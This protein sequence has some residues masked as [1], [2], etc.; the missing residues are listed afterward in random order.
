MV[1][2]GV[3]VAATVGGTV[4]VGGG[5]AAGAVTRP[6]RIAMTI[7]NRSMTAA[8]PH[9][10]G[11]RAFTATPFP[12]TRQV[13]LRVRPI[14]LPVVTIPRVVRCRCRP[15]ILP[16]PYCIGRTKES[17]MPSA[18]S[19]GQ[20]GCISGSYFCESQPARRTTNGAFPVSSAP[21][22]WSFCCWILQQHG[23]EYKQRLTFMTM[24]LDV[25]PLIARESVMP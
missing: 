25:Y 6:I 23:S 3:T 22:S 12:V 13:L 24:Y 20:A 17:P 21:V 2:V 11:D 19:S 10:S 5:A 4:A 15:N 9:T 18:D 7:T 8:S 16:T 1:G 14:L